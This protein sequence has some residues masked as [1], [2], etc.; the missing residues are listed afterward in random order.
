MPT[1]DIT[2]MQVQAVL[3]RARKKDFWDIAM[4]LDHY[5]VEDFIR[6]HEQK[7]SNQNLMVTLPQAI[8]CFADAGSGLGIG[9]K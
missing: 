6:F 9:E 5:S 8:S 7:Y 2:A 1:E 3:G 4:L